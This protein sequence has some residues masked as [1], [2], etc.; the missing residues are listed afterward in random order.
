MINC[1]VL[2]IFV[3]GNPHGKSL[4]CSRRGREGRNDAAGPH[5]K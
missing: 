1:E 4:N 5:P 3:D 2:K